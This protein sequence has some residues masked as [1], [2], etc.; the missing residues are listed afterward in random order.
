[1][2]LFVKKGQSKLQA[3]LSGFDTLTQELE[4]FKEANSA[5]QEALQ[6]QLDVAT[7]EGNRANRVLEKLE[8]LIK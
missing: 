7:E 8:D 4:A 6:I 1:M 3:I 2:N 5:T